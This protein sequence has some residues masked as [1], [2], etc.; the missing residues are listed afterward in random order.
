VEAKG[1]DAESV[2]Q[3]RAVKLWVVKGRKRS[4][5]VGAKANNRGMVLDAVVFKEQKEASRAA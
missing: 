2:S 1:A 3:K 5:A 4:S